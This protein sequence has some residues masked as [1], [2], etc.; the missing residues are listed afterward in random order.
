MTNEATAPQSQ[1]PPANSS[2]DPASPG[3]SS[4]PQSLREIVPH[5]TSAAVAIVTAIKAA[6]W[7]PNCLSILMLPG[8]RISHDLWC[9]APLVLDLL[10]LVAIAAPVSFGNLLELAARLRGGFLQVGSRTDGADERPKGYRGGG[11]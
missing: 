2:G 6:S 1:P 4:P 9:W 3:S 8:G 7:L 11:R 10:A 5:I